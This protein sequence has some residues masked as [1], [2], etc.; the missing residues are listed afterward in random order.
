MA[1]LQRVSSALLLCRWE[2]EDAM[3]WKAR[4]QRS[5]RTSFRPWPWPLTAYSSSNEVAYL[6]PISPYRPTS[7]GGDD[8]ALV[9][10]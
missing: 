2:Y 4:L 6:F 8:V 5:V 7:G 10:V 3:S 9:V 1:R